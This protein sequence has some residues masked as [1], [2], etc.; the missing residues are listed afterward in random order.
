MSETATETLT[1]SLLGDRGT[2]D[3]YYADVAAFTD[4]VMERMSEEVQTIEDFDRFI[5]ENNLKPIDR[6]V[7]AL[8]FLMI[9]VL[10]RVYGRRAT[11]GSIYMGKLLSSLYRIRNR[12]AGAKIAVD[13]LKGIAGTTVLARS[14]RFTDAINLSLFRRM[15]G[16]LRA[17]GEFEQESERLAVWLDFLNKKPSSKSGN[18]LV[19]A[20]RLGYWF[21]GR[22]RERLGCYTSRVAA[23]LNNNGQRLKWK[24]NRIFV[25]RERVEYHL[26]MVGAE[27]MNRAFHGG[28][29]AAKEKRVFLPVCMRHK[30]SEACQAVKDKE[31]YLCRSCSK[32][33]QVN[34]ITAMAKRYGC[35]V[36]VIP[37]ASTAFG[38]RRIREGEVGIVG[39]ACVLNLISGGYKA[40]EMGYEPQC[41]LLHYSGCIQHWHPKGIETTIDLDRLEKI[42]KAGQYFD[43]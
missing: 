14:R 30:S 2:T 25:S 10:W 24:E 11:A 1:Y 28:F 6:A 41:V 18:M 23:Y 15:I 33:C 43:S 42:L 21:E 12:S 31:G 37:H 20:A 3:K 38:H 8:E 39:I 35:K 27:I 16:W 7:Y 22:S 34:L 13:R 9:G 40:K 17:S 26:N 5:A 29:S 32:D 36:V 4:E 19:R